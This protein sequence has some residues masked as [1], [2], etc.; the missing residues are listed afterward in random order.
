MKSAALLLNMGG[1]NNLDEVRTFM[2]NMFDDKNILP[3]NRFIRKLIKKMII[4]K[5]LEDAENNY[6]MLGGKSPLTE[7]SVSL[8]SSVEKIAHMPVR[9]AMRYLPPYA[10]EALEE[11]ERMGVEKIVLFPMYPHYST[12]TTL[13]SYEDILLRLSSMSYNPTIELI[14][15]YYDDPE[16]VDLE[17][18]SIEKAMG[19]RDP[20]EYMLLFSAHGLPVKIIESGDPYREHVKKGCESIKRRLGQR[21]IVFGDDMLAYQSRVGSGEWLQPDLADL[22]R[23]PAKRKVLI[24]PVSFTIDNSETLFELEIEHREIAEKAGCEEYIVAGC[25]NDSD[26][27]ASFV[28]RKISEA[29]G[30]V[31]V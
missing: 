2:E 21:G 14:D 22:L 15:P 29:A 8:A 27:F 13:S 11:F 30:E 25:P 28:A 16:Y 1:P 9:P 23:H 5:R 6:R 7:I 10:D 19:D 26:E 20:S 31:S 18:S 4:K 3:V 12:T 24:Y 17:C